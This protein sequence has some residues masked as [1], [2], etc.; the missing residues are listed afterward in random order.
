VLIIIE[1]ADGMGKTVLAQKICELTGAVYVHRGPPKAHP[2]LEYVAPLSDYDAGCGR[3]YVLD[4]WYVSERV[5]GPSRRGKS[6]IDDSMFK[7][8]NGFMARRGAVIVYCHGSSV[9]AAARIELRDGT[10]ENHLQIARDMHD[11]E[12]ELQS[13]TNVLYSRFESP[14][15]AEEIIFAARLAEENAYA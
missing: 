2:F 12:R 1:G 6:L 5:Y 4:R 9:N 15:T 13:Y 8:I 14:L 11:F 10:I 3:D 7:D